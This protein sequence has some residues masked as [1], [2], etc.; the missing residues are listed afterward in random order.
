MPLTFGIP[1]GVIIVMVGAVLFFGT[2]YKKTAKVVFGMGMFVT[3]L[4]FIL[5]AMALNSN[6]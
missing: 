2:R 6:M 4:T 5:I 1:L 3:L